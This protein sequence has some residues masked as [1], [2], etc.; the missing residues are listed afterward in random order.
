[1][2][3]PAPTSAV[4]S[5]GPH[6]PRSRQMVGRASGPG[7]SRTARARVPQRSGECRTG[8]R[9]PQHPRRCRRGRRARCRWWW[10]WRSGPGPG[11]P[12]AGRPRRGR[13]G[14]GR[15]RE[16]TPIA[17]GWAAAWWRAR[18]HPQP[19]AAVQPC[20][21]VHA[22]PDCPDLRRMVQA[23]QAP[24]GDRAHP[25]P[26][27]ARGS[28]TSA[29]STPTHQH[30]RAQRPE[31]RLR[32]AE[33]LLGGRQVSGW[34]RE[35]NREARKTWA[36]PANWSRCSSSLPRPRAHRHRPAPAAV[37][38]GPRRGHHT[39]RNLAR[40]TRPTAWSKAKHPCPIVNRI[41]LAYGGSDATPCLSGPASGPLATV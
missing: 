13:P 32:Q 40:A 20:Q 21:G 9:G 26:A 6:P 23:H 38:V 33:H 17:L 31:R 27:S 15:R 18:A 25:G 7:S 29:A 35:S 16:G 28:P 24:E 3:R 10:P 19:L 4:S 30:Q 37:F 12:G 39:R 5:A 36:G 34:P 11:A 14:R 41:E 2:P 22:P 8:W 1:M